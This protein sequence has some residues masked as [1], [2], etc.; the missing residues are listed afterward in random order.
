MIVK[1]IHGVDFDVSAV[2]PSSPGQKGDIPVTCNLSGLSLKHALGA[3][4]EGVDCQA[5]LE[6]DK[7]V[8]EPQ[9]GHA[10]GTY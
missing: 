5:R 3:M 4:L 2:A 1:D 7:I 9:P 10:S 8:I 6:G